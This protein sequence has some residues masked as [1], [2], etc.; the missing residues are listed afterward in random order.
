MKKRRIWVAV[1][2]A[3]CLLLTASPIGMKAASASVPDQQVYGGAWTDAYRQILYDHWGPIRQY[4]A[5]VIECTFNGRDYSIP[6]LPVGLNDLTGDGVPELIFMEAADGGARGDLYV[7]AGKDGFTRCI[8]YLAGITR[9]NYDEFLGFSVYFSSAGGNTLVIERYEY[10]TPWVHQYRLNGQGMFELI[11][12]MTVHGDYSGEGEDIFYRNG[13][14]VSSSVYYSALDALQKGVT[15]EISSYLKPDWS[16]Y[17]FDLTWE[18]AVQKLNGMA[19][20][21]TTTPAPAAIYGLAINK[22]AT[23]TG[24]GTKYAE[25][26]TYEVKGQY[27][28]VLAKAYDKV[29]EIW[30]VK[31]VI[32]YRGENRVLWTGYQR[33]DPATLPLEVLPEEHW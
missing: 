3:L 12:T 11:A 15:R 6:C 18:D 20:A 30:W 8:L 22:L 29:N 16:A 21:P 7:Y 5:R 13:Q 23:R 25:G 32:P 26:G 19:S 2:L 17:G 1:L 33:F 31:C 24:P 27:I 9:L 14:V 4:Q 10:E 28:Q